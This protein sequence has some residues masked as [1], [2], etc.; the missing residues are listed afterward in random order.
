MKKNT[1]I[2]VASTK[3]ER[4]SYKAT[5]MLIEAKHPVFPVGFK[6]GKI[7][8]IEIITDLFL[9]KNIDT[10]TLYI[11]PKRQI[12]FYDYILSTQP[13]RIIFNPGTENS[14]L[15]SLAQKQGIKTENACTLVLLRLGQY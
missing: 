10:I 6:P 11:N 3:P 8:N 4:Y 13:N 1:L 14:E 5:Q 7:N 2:F 15:S 9:I 12:E